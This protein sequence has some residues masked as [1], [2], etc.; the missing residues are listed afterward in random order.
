[1]PTTRAAAA[2][3][4]PRGRARRTRRTRRRGRAPR[5]R[6]GR[7]RR[8]TK[9]APPAD[10]DEQVARPRP[11]ASRRD[12]GHLLAPGARRAARRE[13]ARPRRARAGSRRRS[14]AAQPSRATSRSSNGIVR[15]RTPGPARGPC[16]RSGRRR[17]PR[18]RRAR[19]RSRRR[20]RARPRPRAST[21]ARISSMIAAGSSLR[22][23]SEVTIARSAS[24]AAIRPISG[25]LPRSRSP[26]QPKT[27]ITRPVVE[28]ARGAQHVLER[29]GLVRVVDDHLERLALVDRLE[30]PRH[31]AHRLE[32]ARD[33]LVVDAR[34]AA[35]RRARR[36]RSR[37]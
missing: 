30:P 21:P 28:L 17:P 18:P 10:G 14:E 33:R 19:A 27:Q 8:S 36:A 20:G 13:R 1:M 34:A 35:P 2:R 11:G 26:P 31:A 12:A 29:V 9:S 6:R 3:R 32:P 24:S 15:R 7:A 16:R 5:R 22:G 37:R 23:L 25:R 4:A